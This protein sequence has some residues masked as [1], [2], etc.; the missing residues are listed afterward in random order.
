MAFI[1][2]NKSG[3]ND[4]LFAAGATDGLNRIVH[5]NVTVMK[6]ER[7]KTPS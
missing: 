6:D 3:Q 2:K 7:D 4:Q 1:L 5:T